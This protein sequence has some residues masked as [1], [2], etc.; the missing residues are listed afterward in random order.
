MKTRSTA[1][2]FVVMFLASSVMPLLVSCADMSEPELSNESSLAAL[3]MVDAFDDGDVSDWQPFTGGGATMTNRLSSSYANSGTTS[4]KLIYSVPSGGYAGV[5][6][7]F[8]APQNW[9]AGSGLGIWVYGAATSHRFLIQ[10]YDAG[11]ERWEYR[12]PVDFQGWKQI[13]I[14]FTS[15]TAASWQPS[16]ARVDGV[17]D[18]AQATGIA[19]APA[20]GGGTGSVYVDSVALVAASAPTSVATPA[21]TIVPLYSN[22]SSAAWSAVAAAKRANPSVPVLAV[23][24]PYNGPGTSAQSNYT[25]SIASLVSAGVKV[26]GYVYTSYGKRLAGD[27]QADVDRYRS[28]YPGVTGIF[29]DEMATTVGLES[30]YAGL[31]AYAKSHGFD[32]TIGNPGSDSRASYVGTVDVILIYENSGLP[33]AT[34]MA[35]WHSGYDKKN[36][37][38]IP[39]AVAM[40]TAFVQTA[41][42]S[43]GYIYLQNDNLPNPWDTVPSYFGSLV[44]ALAQ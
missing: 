15:L 11:G 16:G 21:G 9:S 39:Y 22:P 43:V 41:R 18:L 44:T 26:I 4:M 12:F 33:T 7:R 38:I 42:S 8:P 29:F 25:S 32:F 6:K 2:A 10:V 28:F 23:I 1:P 34:R 14:P 17:R 27:V 36:F 5:E 20:E 40:D 37:G 13:T 31:T 19:L 3:S 35:G 24:N 30:Y